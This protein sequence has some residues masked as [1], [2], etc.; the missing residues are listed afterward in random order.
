VPR[1]PCLLA[2][3]LATFAAVDA[4]ADAWRA[5]PFSEASLTLQTVIGQLRFSATVTGSKPTRLAKVM[6]FVDGRVLDVPAEAYRD[7]VN[8]RLQE[9]MALVPQDCSPGACN[10]PAAV[11]IRY[12]PALG[13]PK[14]PKTAACASSWLRIVFDRERVQRASVVECLG[15]KHE[16]ERPV[17]LPAP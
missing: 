6:L 1:L 17:N 9:T 5:Q 10:A 8:P 15:S 2:T 14:L 13:N 11:M 7:V 3:A 16:R 12:Y 4:G